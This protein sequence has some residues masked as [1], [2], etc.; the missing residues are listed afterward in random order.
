M[1]VTSVEKKCNNFRTQTLCLLRNNLVFFFASFYGMEG[2]MWLR[3]GIKKKTGV[4][5]HYKLDNF[6]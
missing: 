4:K 1:K 5:T 6:I 2:N 3:S